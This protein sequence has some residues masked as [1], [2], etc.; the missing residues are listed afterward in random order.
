MSAILLDVLLVIGIL[1]IA[2]LLVPIHF[3]FQGGYAQRVNFQGRIRWTGGFLS[4][5]ITRSEGKI[6]TSLGLLGIKKHMS[7]G[8][9]T[10][11]K[12]Q[13]PSPEKGREKSSGN[14][15]MDFISRQLFAA[16]K[17]LLGKLIRAWHLNINLAGIY[18]F[19]DPSLTGIVMG[20]IATFQYVSG[21]IDLSPDF[22]E[23]VVDIQGSIRGWFVPLQ[24]LV[25]ALVFI[26]KKPV[27]ALWW[28]KIKIKRKQKEAVQYA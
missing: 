28:P 27:R 7:P 9:G 12:D 13:K 5:D 6:Q 22:T 24:V 2:I 17:D 15:I 11:R 18:G 8:A 1:L 3:Y 21:S 4:L 23:A 10:S 16:V 20:L 14:N 19:E 25:I 26:F